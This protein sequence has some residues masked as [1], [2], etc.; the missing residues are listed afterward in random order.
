VRGPAAIALVT[1]LSF[2]PASEGL[3]GAGSSRWRWAAISVQSLPESMG[4]PWSL[5][6]SGVDHRRVVYQP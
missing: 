5:R 4:S 1:A 3:A 2:E 6:E